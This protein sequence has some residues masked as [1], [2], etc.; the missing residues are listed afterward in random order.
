MKFCN[1][2]FRHNPL[3]RTKESF[4]D[5]FFRHCVEND[6]KTLFIAEQNGNLYKPHK[7]ANAM[8]WRVY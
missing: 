6:T 7:V 8:S 1:K 3:L 2:G 5:M 4:Y